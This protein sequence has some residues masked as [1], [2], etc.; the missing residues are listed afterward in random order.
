MD[1][2]NTN[3]SRRRF[4]Q[5]TGVTGAAATVALGV[6]GTGLESTSAQAQT[7][8]RQ[9]NTTVTKNICHQC[10]ARCG[11]DVYTTDGRVHAIHGNPDHP[12]A[13]GKLCP[14]GPLG[15]ISFMTR[16]AGVARCGAPTRRRVAMSI[17][18]SCQSAGTRRWIWLPNG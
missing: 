12:I 15:V 11:I 18:V 2:I 6:P 5:A 14:K 13:N 16:T 17:R 1:E 7:A 3:V 10:P 8:R 4:L 9:P